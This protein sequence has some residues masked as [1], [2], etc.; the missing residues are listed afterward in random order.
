MN[1]E[2]PQAGANHYLVL[3]AICLSAIFLI[4]MESGLFTANLLA[5][6]IG[7]SALAWK[8]R[9]GPLLLVILVAIGQLTLEP[10]LGRYFGPGRY[11]QG[12]QLPDVLL[13]AAVLG[14]VVGHYRLQAIWF[15]ILPTDSRQ[16]TEAP[17]HGWR[18]WW[19][20]PTVL[21]EQRPA[22][23]ITAK[24]I[25]FLVVTLPIWAV[26]GQLAWELVPSG[27][28]VLGLPVRLVQILV[29][30]WTLAIGGYLTSS[31][32]GFW[33]FRQQDPTAAQLYLQDQLWR[34]TRGEQRRINRWLAWWRLTKRPDKDPMT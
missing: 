7:M 25:A 3:C 18:R 14:Y 29:V 19:K 5:L 10:G 34:E 27:L 31:F 11:R 15:H 30:L 21:S 28:N 22:R 26:V 9:L 33:R 16:L 1:Q 23:H 6:L 12:M 2:E 24:E 13:C 17:P 32:L 4:Q 20:R 8:L